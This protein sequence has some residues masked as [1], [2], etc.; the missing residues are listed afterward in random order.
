M[1]ITD[2]SVYSNFVET[3]SFSL[4]RSNTTS[5]FIVRDIVGLDAEEIIP[6]FYG[7]GLV[8]TSPLNTKPRF[9]NLGM[10]PRNVVIRVAL[11]PNFKNDESYS[12]V[13]DELYRNISS[14]RTGLIVLHF[15]SGAT[16]VGRLLGFITKFEVSHFTQ[17][18][19]AQLTIRCDDPLFRA[20]N[21]VTFESDDLTT[22]NPV[23]IADSLSTAPHG[24]TMKV[25]FTAAPA[26]FTIQDFSSSPEWKFKILPITPFAAGDELYLCSDYSSRY[27]YMIRSSVT[28][29]LVDRIEPGSIWPVIFPGINEFHFVNIASFNWNYLEYYAAY[30]GV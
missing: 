18:P 11:N 12:D 3:V 20:I 4:S 23:I 28:T 15:Y 25:T 16:T 29:P 13:R 14:N 22:V 17:L 10:K 6:K 27:V 26:T 9:Y 19:E 21:P 8:S 24:F 1:R 30:W 7:F 2:I 5:K